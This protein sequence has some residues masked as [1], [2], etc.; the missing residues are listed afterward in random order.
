[1]E[2]VFF[3]DYENVDTKGLDGVSRLTSNDV[4]YFFYSENHS[5]M[6]FGLHRRIEESPASF[7]YIKVKDLTKNGLDRE[8]ISVADERICD[9]R[10]DYYII[11]NDKGY[12]SFVFRKSPAYRVYLLSNIVEANDAK[13]A[14]LRQQIKDRLVNCVG[15]SYDL[16]SEAIDTIA[17]MIFDSQDKC[18]LN[19]K[20]QTMFY[21]QD[22][23]YI[24]S[25]IED[26]TY[27]M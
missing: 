6:T 23:K 20:L 15:K 19:E 14:W 17:R 24:F 4:V 9:R 16:N 11:S 2:R 25:K 13:R 18:E 26:L 21:N 3:I 5:R 1:M 8:L 27:N 7:Y 10:S 12:S 22:V